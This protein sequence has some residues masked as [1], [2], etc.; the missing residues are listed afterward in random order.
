MTDETLR[1]SVSRA[2]AGQ[3][4]ADLGKFLIKQRIERPNEGRSGGFRAIV[5]FKTG[6]V[7]VFLHMFPKSV[8]D[9]LSPEELEVFR[10]V[11]KRFA[12]LSQDVI[13]RLIA[14]QEWIEIDDDEAEEGLP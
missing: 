5:V 9:N 1:D 11:A 12:A 13:K 7:A 8:Q 6:D 14:E 10:E 2:E 4:D 3:I